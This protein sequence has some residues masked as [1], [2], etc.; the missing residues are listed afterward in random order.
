MEIN[1]LTTMVENV[2]VHLQFKQKRL[3]KA[4]TVN[5]YKQCDQLALKDKSDHER[6]ITALQRKESKSDW[7]F[8]SK[9]KSTEELE[10][11]QRT[12]SPGCFQKENVS[13]RLFCKCSKYWEYYLYK[14]IQLLNLV[15][16][17]PQAHS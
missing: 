15:C 12:P 7:Y 17:P 14:S 3:D 16:L 8:K 1:N 11:I 5:D 4:K 2:K 10:R 6:Q 9:S 13:K